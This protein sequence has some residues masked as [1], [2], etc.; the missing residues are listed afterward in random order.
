MYKWIK[1]FNELLNQSRTIH[2]NGTKNRFSSRINWS[3]AKKREFASGWRADGG[4]KKKWP[5]HEWCIWVTEARNRENE[6]SVNL[7]AVHVRVRDIGKI[8][9]PLSTT[10][11]DTESVFDE[12]LPIWFFFLLFFFCRFCLFVCRDPNGVWVNVCVR[13]FGIRFI[14]TSRAFY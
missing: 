10:V 12:R 11:D 1:K 14:Y 6:N 13:F 8:G 7:K 5:D 2:D 9:A 4:R 3:V